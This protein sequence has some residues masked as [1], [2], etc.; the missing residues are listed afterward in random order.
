MHTCYIHKKSDLQQGLHPEWCSQEW[1]QRSCHQGHSR[2]VHQRRRVCLI[3]RGVSVPQTGLQCRSRLREE[4]G[5]ICISGWVG[6]FAVA[7]IRKSFKLFLFQVNNGLVTTMLPWLRPSPISSRTT[8]L[9]EV[10]SGLLTSMTSKESS[11]GVE[12][13]LS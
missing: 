9:V 6:N 11:V 1:N 12:S 13:T 3:L 7:N 8:A 2:E 10:W 4:D 5:T